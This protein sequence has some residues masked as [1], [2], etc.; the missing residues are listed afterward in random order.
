M[1]LTGPDRAARYCLIEDKSACGVRLRTRSDFEA[2]SKFV[3]QL[4]DTEATYKVV[5]RTGQVV[6]AER[7]SRVNHLP[8]RRFGMLEVD[9]RACAFRFL[10]QPSRPSAL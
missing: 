2:P 9:T 10:R 3:L 4:A 1:I 6:G 5:W 8:V 7:V